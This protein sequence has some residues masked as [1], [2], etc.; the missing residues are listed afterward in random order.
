M[1]L[2][3]TSTTCPVARARALPLHM[4]FQGAPIVPEVLPGSVLSVTWRWRSSLSLIR[5]RRTPLSHC[6]FQLDSPFSHAPNALREHYIKRSHIAPLCYRVSGIKSSSMLECC[7]S[8]NSPDSFN[9]RCATCASK[10][11]RQIA[12]HCLYQSDAC[13][14]NAPRA[15]ALSTKSTTLLP[16]GHLVTS[17]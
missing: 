17:P 7:C 8:I 12:I 2:G 14:T 5:L 3:S 13:T 11:A 1:S 10:A 15:T 16:N 4:R 9:F 6:S